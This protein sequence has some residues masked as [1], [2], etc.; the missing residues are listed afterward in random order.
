MTLDGTFMRWLMLTSGFV[1]WDSMY[2]IWSN[3][4]RLFVRLDVCVLVG[5]E[6]ELWFGV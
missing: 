3:L 1:S 4:N 5:C 2:M 6:H